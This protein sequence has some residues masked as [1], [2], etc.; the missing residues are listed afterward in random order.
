MDIL[1]RGHSQLS[2]AFAF[3]AHDEAIVTDTSHD[4]RTKITNKSHA[5][6]DT[7]QDDTH[8]SLSSSF[9]A[10]RAP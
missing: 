4:D 3:N 9:N 2:R 6:N 1:R 8:H 7:A 5:R 10:K